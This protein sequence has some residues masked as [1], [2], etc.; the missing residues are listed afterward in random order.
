MK[1]ECRAERAA[2][3]M[4]PVDSGERMIERKGARIS[5]RGIEEMSISKPRCHRSPSH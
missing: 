4:G 5:A 2:D 1:K 3:V